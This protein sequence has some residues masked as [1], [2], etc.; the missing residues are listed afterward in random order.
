MNQPFFTMQ[1]SIVGHI[2]TRALTLTELE[3]M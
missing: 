3:Q 1:K 2:H